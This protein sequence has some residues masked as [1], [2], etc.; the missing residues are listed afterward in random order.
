MSP[1]IP[2]K[3]SDSREIRGRKS[4]THRAEISANRAVSAESTLSQYIYCV[5]PATAQR[6]LNLQERIPAQERIGSDGINTICHEDIAAIVSPAEPVDLENM[7][8][9]NLA[10]LL[11]THQK[12][13]ELIMESPRAVI[14]FRLGTYAVTEAEVV[15]ILSK[16]SRLIRRLFSEIGDRIELDVVATWANFTS[17]LKE[18]CEEDEIKK[19]KEA[20]G[21][22]PK[23]ISIDDQMKVGLMVKQT[24]DRKRLEISRQIAERLAAVSGAQRVHE[25]MNDQ[26]VMNCAFLVEAA[27][28][29]EFEHALDEL[30]A[31][32]TEKLKFR[33]VGPLAPYSFHTLDLKRIQ[34]QAVDSAHQLLG[35]DGVAS[36]EDIKR[37]FRHS[38][39]A[40][41][42]DHCGQTDT[43]ERDFDKLIR[44]RQIVL[45]YLQACE[46]TE[47]AAPIVFSE[48]NVRQNSL[49]VKVRNENDH[50]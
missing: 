50:G 18:T 20:L 35:L 45:E 21:G 28:R 1:L 49:L 30:D 43:A 7:R 15:K 13:I 17:A 9:D 4:L 37:A 5:I 8:R 40:R 19:Y 48:E 22:D 44:A 36:P 2:L 3:Q 23:G 31:Q 10:K 24:L 14:P 29:Q 39:M 38:A 42:P 33:C 41:H 12:V 34:W 27:R 16:G 6:T 25:N 47:S 11:L 32:F 46:Q 26:M